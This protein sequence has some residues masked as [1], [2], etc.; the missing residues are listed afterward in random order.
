MLLPASVAFATNTD[1]PLT[2]RENAAFIVRDEWTAW[3]KGFTASLS[4]LDK[5][6][7][8]RI[9][10]NMDYYDM[11][12][13]FTEK[14]KK[15]PEYL[16]ED[17]KPTQKLK[18]LIKAKRKQLAGA[19]TL[20]YLCFTSKANGSKVSYAKLGVPD[21]SMGISYD[22]VS[23]S[24]WD[25]SEVT[26]DSGK[27]IYVWN[28]KN[29]IVGSSGS[30][31]KFSVT[32]N[33]ELSGDI[34]SL[35][36]F[37]DSLYAG[38]YGEFNQL[39]KDCTGITNAENL[40]LP[41]ASAPKYSYAEMFKGC[42]NLQTAPQ[43]FANNVGEEGCTE[44][45][46]GC[47]ELKAAPDLYA[48]VVGVNAFNG[49]FSGCSKLETA[50][51]QLPA[52]VVRDGSYAFMFKD[53]VLLKESPYIAA[54]ALDVRCF[55]EMFN[56]CSTLH[57]IS[58]GYKRNIVGSHVPLDA[59]TD[60]VAGV[61]DTG[62]FY[63]DID[64]SPSAYTYGPSAFPK[65]TGTEWNIINAGINYLTFTST[66]DGSTVGWSTTSAL[67]LNNIY[68]SKDKTN[69][70]KWT[71]GASVNIVL[72]NGEQLYI[73]NKDNTLSTGTTSCFRFVIPNTSFVEVSGNAHSLLNFRDDLSGDCC[74][75][76][77]FNSCSG[78]RS[79]AKLLLPALTTK[80][81]CYYYMFYNCS[82]LK[83]AP[84]LPATSVVDGCYMDMFNGCT[85]LKVAPDLPATNIGGRCY[86]R[87]FSGCT[88]LVTAPNRLPG[89]DLKWVS[90]AE[91]FKNCRK[92]TKAPE[93]N[94]T[95][96]SSTDCLIQMFEGC[97]SLKEIRLVYNGN[98]NPHFVN[99]VSGVPTTGGTF[100]YSGPD[101]SNF[102]PSAIPGTSAEHWTVLPYTP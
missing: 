44:M 5:N 50:P 89:S 93:I 36:N 58:I 14:Y 54:T 73:W 13:R 69:W 17:G 27:S 96:F 66:R 38:E 23:F 30:R 25:G 53:C 85:N 8:S 11:Q 35:V 12:Y 94:I 7:T 95:S 49:M 67:T 70:T 90:Y 59:F 47:T 40:V 28:K 1:R 46:A 32:E 97:N 10:D 82:N 4:E 29:H 98:F 16:D 75:V 99:W 45:F 101:T 31:I 43:I 91:M 48:T 2:D 77:L 20:D 3:V 78:L 60:W 22:G 39:F 64:M 56:G 100:Y 55:K 72:N 37:G 51:T 65:E 61:A 76:N 6:A 24:P 57:E 83:E 9:Y 102:G 87:M 41:H 33:V 62:N 71:S 19:K 15:V 21:I 63:C 81:L 79:A 34:S 92:L 42:T 68:Y 80:S 52:N 86:T 88:A 26:L 74:F 18:D 84:A